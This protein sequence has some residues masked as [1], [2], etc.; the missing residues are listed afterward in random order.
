MEKLQQRITD[1]LQDTVQDAVGSS[2]TEQYDQ[3]I[4]A[5]GAKSLDITRRNQEEEIHEKLPHA[6]HFRC[7][8]TKESVYDNMEFAFPLTINDDQNGF[9]T[10]LKAV[11]VVIEQVEKA[12]NNEL[13]G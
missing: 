6:I 13:L 7:G 12:S 3:H 11:K 10:L 4:S 9:N 2:P 5:V 1:S 8:A